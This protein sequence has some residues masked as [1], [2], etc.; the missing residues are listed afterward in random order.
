MYPPNPPTPSRPFAEDGAEPIATSASAEWVAAAPE[1]A[2]PAAGYLSLPAHAPVPLPAVAPVPPPVAASVRPARRKS[3]RGLLL[4][5]IGCLLL[6]LACGALT[7]AQYR[8]DRSPQTVVRQYFAALAAGDAAAALGYADVPP[9]GDYL[10]DVVLHQQL[11]LAPLAGLVVQDSR[12]SGGRG[13]VSVRYRLQFAGGD[14]QVTDT[15]P[16]IRHGSSWRLSQVAVATTVSVTSTGADRLTLAGGR[17]PS[18]PVL[19]FPGALP[20]GTDYPAVQVAGRPSVR[21]GAAEQQTSQVGVSLT[22]AAKS[23]LQRGVEQALA[24]CLTGKAAPDCPV[25]GDSRPVPGSL[26]GTA[27]PMATPLQI[28]LGMHGEIQLTGTVTVRGSWQD[29]DFNNQPVVRT[30]DT[31]LD[32]HASASITDLNT[33]YWNWS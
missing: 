17:L 16:V 28:S 22:P 4:A 2:D 19:L 20:L 1:P 11:R 3:R 30:G 14:E 8:T 29:W 31:D 27:L 18:G 9:K 23:S 7:I 10:T 6:A 21:L 33:I 12:L 25:A 24:E 32:L 5:G 26:R 15:V 13:T